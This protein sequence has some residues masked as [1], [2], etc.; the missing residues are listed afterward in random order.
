MTT[1]KDNPQKPE[2]SP[3]EVELLAP[4]MVIAHLLTHANA[5]ISQGDHRAVHKVVDNYIK[6]RERLCKD[7]ND[8]KFHT[9]SICSN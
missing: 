9:F 2:L 4:S 8:I 1:P 6:L 7:F 5:D 3:H